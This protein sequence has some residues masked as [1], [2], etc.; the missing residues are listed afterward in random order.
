MTSTLAPFLA[1][2]AR[3]A[4]ADQTRS[5]PKSVAVTALDQKSTGMTLFFRRACF[6]A[7][8]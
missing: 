5:A 1:A 2:V 6:F 8:S 4:H 3:G 7:I